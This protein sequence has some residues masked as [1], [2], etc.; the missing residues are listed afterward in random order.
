MEVGDEAVDL[1]GLAFGPGEKERD[2]L[3][4]TLF[5]FLFSIALNCICVSELI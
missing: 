4:H 1:I 2:F 5:Y 3:I